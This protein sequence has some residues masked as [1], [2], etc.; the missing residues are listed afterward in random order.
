MST[1]LKIKLV[2]TVILV[3]GVSVLSFAFLDSQV[4]IT[5]IGGDLPDVNVGEA[6]SD[7][8]LT[9]GISPFISALIEV[10]KVW[11]WIPDST[12]GKVNAIGNALAYIILVLAQ[13]I[14]GIDP[15][16]SGVQQFFAIALLVVQGIL[17]I[18]GAWLSFKA[19]RA[20]QVQRLKAGATSVSTKG[21]FKP[22]PERASS[23]V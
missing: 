15:A 10:C 18:S 21:L 9:L 22:L 12:A 1:E 8:L 7:L 16:A 17:A 6:A 3:V 2:I 20:V 5:P 14:W 4:T 13:G 19:I 23:W 11:G